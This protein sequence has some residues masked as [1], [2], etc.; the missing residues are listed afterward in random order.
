MIAE[1]RNKKS[2]RNKAMM[3]RSKLVMSF[4]DMEKHMATLGHDMS[5]LQDKHRAAAEKSR[6]V[7][8]GADVVFGQNDSMA[9]GSNGGKLRQSDR[10][11][12]GVADGS[13]RS[14]ADRMAKLQRRQRNRDA[15]QGEADRH[16]TA[17]LPKHL[18]SGKRGIGKSDFR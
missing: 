17:S 9:S 1:A 5:S 18:F 11:L 4:G 3:P 13:M 2:L 6:Y 15:R 14:K 8:T 16:A 12:D 10:L 7:E